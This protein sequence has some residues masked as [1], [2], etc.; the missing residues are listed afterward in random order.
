MV[1][2]DSADVFDETLG[3]RYR[4]RVRARTLATLLMQ[5]EGESAVQPS[6]DARDLMSVVACVGSPNVLSRG[7]A[8]WMGHGSK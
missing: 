1:G 2:L 8:A 6:K 4:M 3:Q 5:H 7:A